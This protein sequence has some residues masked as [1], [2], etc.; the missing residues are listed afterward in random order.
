[1]MSLQFNPKGLVTVGGPDD[2][3][4]WLDRSSSQLTSLTPDQFAKPGSWM[5]VKVRCDGKS[6]KVEFNGRSVYQSNVI[7]EPPTGSIRFWPA[8]GLEVMNVFV[9]ELKEK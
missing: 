6:L 3:L 8:E 7:K 9:R 1:M 4:A 2:K 5:R